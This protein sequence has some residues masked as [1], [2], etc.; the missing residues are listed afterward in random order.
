[1]LALSLDDGV[2]DAGLA[3]RLNPEKLSE[4]ITMYVHRNSQQESRIFAVFLGLANFYI[5]AS[6]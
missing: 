5:F 4:Y 1:M 2:V 3:V 6:R